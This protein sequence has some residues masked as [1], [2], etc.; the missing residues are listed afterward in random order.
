LSGRHAECIQKEAVHAE[1]NP[2]ARLLIDNPERLQQYP[3]TNNDE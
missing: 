1:S 2:G 3:Q